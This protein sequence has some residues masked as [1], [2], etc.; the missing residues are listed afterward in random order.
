MSESMTIEATI[1]C[2]RSGKGR[3][4]LRAATCGS[5]NPGLEPGRI[6]RIARLLALAI[7]LDGLVQEGTIKNYADAAKMGH[8]TRA[9]ISQIMNLRLLAP[10]IQEEILFSKRTDKGRDP[11]PLRDLQPIAALSAWSE[12]RRLWRTLAK[13][14]S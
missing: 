11:I 8:V 10:D 14:R 13:C 1:Q 5:T 3:K 12:Q 6:P 7:R 4:I 9:R 2:H